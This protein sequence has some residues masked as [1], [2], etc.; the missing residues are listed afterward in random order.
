MQAVKDFMRSCVVINTS[1]AQATPTSPFLEEDEALSRD[2]EPEPIVTIN[3]TPVV[4]AFSAANALAAACSAFLESSRP[5]ECDQFALDTCSPGQ[6][7]AVQC[8][9]EIYRELNRT[10]CVSTNSGFECRC[11]L[12]PC[13]F[14]AWEQYNH[15]SS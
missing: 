12:D 7:G 6:P 8:A 9:G 1:A 5:P 11:A 4:A 2:F 15:S 14:F 13:L 10:H 3:G